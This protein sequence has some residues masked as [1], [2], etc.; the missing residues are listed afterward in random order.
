VI[1][2]VYP[3]TFTLIPDLTTALALASF[4][5]FEKV[6]DIIDHPLATSM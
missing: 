4:D 3:T 1:A 5:Q 2:R 6:V